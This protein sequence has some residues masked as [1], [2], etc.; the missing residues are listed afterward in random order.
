MRLSLFL[1]LFIFSPAILF[2][3]EKITITTYYPSPNGSY[4][5]LGVNKLAVDISGVAVDSEYTA[6]DN[7]DVHIGGSLIIGAGA[8][9]GYAYD[10]GAVTGDGY[11]I[12]KG[13]VGIG[14]TNPNNSL[15]VKDLLNFDDTNFGTYL[16]Y[17]AGNSN[18]ITGDYNSFIGYKSGF[19]NITGG[20]NTA[21]GAN[22]LY[23][24]IAGFSNTALG[25]SALY[26]NTV[27]NY[28]T[29]LGYYALYNTTGSNNTALG[30]AAGDNITTGSGNI[31]I[32]NNVD[33]ISATGSNTLNIGNVLFGTG[34]NGAIGS[35]NIG[36][37][38]T[39][40]SGARLVVNG[41]IKATGGRAVFMTNAS[42]GPNAGYYSYLPTCY[43][44]LCGST[45][46][47]DYASG[48]NLYRTC[49]AADSV[50]PGACNQTASQP[51]DNG[52]AG[53]LLLY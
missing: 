7:G 9:S 5:E 37:G 45:G 23:S 50:T 48:T 16:G 40:T 52:Q 14:T 39:D 47:S 22:S 19:S 28:N 17:Q 49:A 12:V 11:L 4:N 21:V 36:I 15:Q 31:V 53:R 6:M 25:D 18:N 43:T 20:N 29:A 35:G 34:M 46:G 26:K 38:T 41:S 1:V 24:N 33:A 2:A 13:R 32:G 27:G 3:E 8:G 30:Y 10:E 51:C 44:A 42:C